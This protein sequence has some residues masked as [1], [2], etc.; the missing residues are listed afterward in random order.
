MTTA[1]FL[2]RYF[3][4]LPVHL[5]VMLTVAIVA[6]LA[7]ICVMYL[8]FGGV[9]YTDDVPLH[10]ALA[11]KPFVFFECTDVWFRHFPPLLALLET[12]LLPATEIFGQFF[13]VRIYYGLWDVVGCLLLLLGLRQRFTHLSPLIQWAVMLGPLNIYACS[14]SAQDESIGFT[15]VALVFF[16]YSMGRI[17]LAWVAA[18]LSVLVGKVMLLALLAGMGLVW[19]RSQSASRIALGIGLFLMLAPYVM[20]LGCP[21]QANYVLGAIHTISFWQALFPMMG[22]DWHQ[23]FRWSTGVFLIAAVLLMLLCMRHQSG[24]VIRDRLP[25]VDVVIC[26]PLLAFFALSYHVVPEYFLLVLPF[27]WL[28]MLRQE[29]NEV[30]IIGVVGVGYCLPLVPDVLRYLVSI[31]YDLPGLTFFHHGA[32]IILSAAT[33]CLSIAV[34]VVERRLLQT[35]VNADGAEHHGIGDG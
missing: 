4:W 1:P 9:E 8:A 27:L 26:L 20:T 33:F 10:L 13:G 19:W 12:G 17:N 6:R 21:H 30:S 35:E 15:C 3:H 2:Q 18:A 34:L 16:L 7:V 25:A 5:G 28:L 29:W 31:K 11:A 22:Y 14:V 24:L 32:T 23:A